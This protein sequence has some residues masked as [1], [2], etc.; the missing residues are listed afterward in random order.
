ML[1]RK[2]FLILSVSSF[3]WLSPVIASVESEVQDFKGTP[4]T[5]KNFTE[6]FS[7]PSIKLEL[8]PNTPFPNPPYNLKE[9]RA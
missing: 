6:I 3:F 2:I 8:K 4:I 5:V 7:I 1:V 9:I